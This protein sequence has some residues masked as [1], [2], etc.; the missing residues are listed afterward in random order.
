MFASMK[1]GFQGQETFWRRRLEKA[2]KKFPD[3]E[4]DGAVVQALYQNYMELLDKVGT[5]KGIVQD[6]LEKYAKGVGVSK[7]VVAHN[8]QAGMAVAMMESVKGVKKVKSVKPGVMGEAEEARGAEVMRHDAALLK[9][10]HQVQA[11]GDVAAS[12]QGQ[13]QVDTLRMLNCLDEAITE[14]GEIEWRPDSNLLGMLRQLEGYLQK[15]AGKEVAR[16]IADRVD[17]KPQA[18][19]RPRID[20]GG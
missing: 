6:A 12:G 3:H 4:N 17:P 10:H 15:D 7:K 20:G 2:Q 18:G 8:Q 1:R 5:K 14:A 9:Q 13:V 19:V 11:A 16:D